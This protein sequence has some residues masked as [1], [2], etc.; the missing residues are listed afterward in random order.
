MIKRMLGEMDVDYTMLSDPTEVL[1][2]RPMA[3]TAC[4]LA[5]PPSPKSGSRAER[6]HHPAAATVAPGKDEEIRRNHLEPRRAQAEHPDGRGL[7]R[8]VPDE[9]VG[10]HRQ[11]DSGFAW[12]KNAAA[13]WT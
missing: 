6:R 5:A 7:D 4:T 8:R 12:P 1:T 2:P 13:A 11:A 10:S 9:G 3:N